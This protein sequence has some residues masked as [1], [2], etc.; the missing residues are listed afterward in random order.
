MRYGYKAK[1]SE[2]VLKILKSPE[3]SRD[4]ADAIV[5]IRRDPKMRKAELN[6]SIVSTDPRPV[7]RRQ[8]G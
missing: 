1:Y 2:S 6:G 5:R 3:K 7:A 4:L 8:G